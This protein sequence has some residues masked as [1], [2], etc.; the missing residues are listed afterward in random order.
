MRHGAQLGLC[1]G[2][3][4]YDVSRCAESE[5]Q[6]RAV[7]HQ[8]QSIANFSERTDALA[9]ALK[10]SLRDLAER[11]G[12][13]QAMLFAYRTGKQPI[14][15][16]AWRKLEAA[17]SGLL[18]PQATA[19]ARSDR[20][21]DAPPFRYTQPTS[22][23]L[24]EWWKDLPPAEEWERAREQVPRVYER[25]KI[26]AERTFMG[27]IASSCGRKR[28]PEQ[29]HAFTDA[30]SDLGT[31]GTHAAMQ[32]EFEVLVRTYSHELYK[33]RS[34][35]LEERLA[36]QAREITRQRSLLEQIRAWWDDNATP[37]VADKVAASRR[38]RERLEKRDGRVGSEPASQATGE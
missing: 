10:I 33:L 20:V 30:L 31:P 22:P 38:I 18:N 37:G 26:A 9:S 29:V 1:V 4:R 25:M 11:I 5:R 6:I 3:F 21:E 15:L 7:Q 17:E 19:P 34:E 13:S 2:L 16:K 14:S 32:P 8:N 35:P 23:Q 24:P 12:I 36:V 28:S 27:D